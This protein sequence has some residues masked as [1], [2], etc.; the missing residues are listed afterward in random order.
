MRQLF[1]FS[2]NHRRA[3]R[4]PPG[5]GDTGCMQIPIQFRN[6]DFQGKSHS[7]LMLPCSRSRKNLR[8]L[9]DQLSHRTM[10]AEYCTVSNGTGDTS[11]SSSATLFPLRWNEA[12]AYTQRR[13]ED[14]A[15]TGIYLMTKVRLVQRP[16]RPNRERKS[17]GS[18]VD[19][20]TSGNTASHRLS[21]SRANFGTGVLVNICNRPTVPNGS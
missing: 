21:P 18:M 4:L 9:A 12:C 15:N 3:F 17:G 6:G 1:R 20:E 11:L 5:C 10:S 13:S 14:G 16:N 2:S 8:S 7:R 19:S